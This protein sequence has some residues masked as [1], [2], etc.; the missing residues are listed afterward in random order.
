MKMRR[1]K[2]EG[3]TNKPFGATDRRR[4][5]ADR[6]VFASDFIGRHQP[7]DDLVKML[8]SPTATTR[9][10]AARLLGNQQAAVAIPALV[11]LLKDDV[12]GVHDP[13]STALAQMGSNALFPLT[14]ALHSRRGSQGFRH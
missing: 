13:A 6:R 14:D 2:D 7:T 5:I 8:K 12:P 9:Q 10:F 3:R 4:A 11:E 1:G